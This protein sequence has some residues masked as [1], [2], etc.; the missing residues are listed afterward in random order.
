[1]WSQVVPYAAA[2]VKHTLQ[3]ARYIGDTVEAGYLATIA[4]LREEPQLTAIFASND[5]PALGAMNAIADLGMNVPRDISV[6]GITD[7]QWARVSRP[8]LTT[9]AVPT[10]EAARMSIDLLLALIEG[11]SPSPVMR[12]TATPQLVQRASTAVPRKRKA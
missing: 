4:L 9:V 6:I 1:M 12:V 11:R 8:A 2:G 10:E 7:I 5:L 3:S